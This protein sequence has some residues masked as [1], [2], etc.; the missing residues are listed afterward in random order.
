VPVAARAR[1]AA[2]RPGS[3]RQAEPSVD[4]A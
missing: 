3:R 2:S 4:R 1:S